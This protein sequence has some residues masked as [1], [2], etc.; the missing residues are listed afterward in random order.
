MRLTRGAVADVGIDLPVVVRL[1]GTNAS[2]G[3]QILKDSGLAIIAAEG[4]AE[5]AEK[6]VGAAR[7]NGV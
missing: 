7:R 3:R 2:Q 4:L 6:A 5:A 1:E